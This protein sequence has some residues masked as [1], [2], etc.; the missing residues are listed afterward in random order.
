M[1]N[2]AETHPAP[3][4][5]NHQKCRCSNTPT[6]VHMPCS[7]C[8]GHMPLQQLDKQAT[9]KEQLPEGTAAATAAALLCKTTEAKPPGGCFLKP[10]S[11]SWNA[12]QQLVREPKKASAQRLEETKHTHRCPLIIH[13]QTVQLAHQQGKTSLVTGVHNNS[14]TAGFCRLLQTCMHPPT[15]HKMQLALHARDSPAGGSTAKPAPPR[16]RHCTGV[17]AV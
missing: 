9:N 11:Y 16:S 13:A 3:L 15:H 12:C 2:H 14:K 1:S 5:P 10:T 17:R 8:K 6:T 4:S 7:A